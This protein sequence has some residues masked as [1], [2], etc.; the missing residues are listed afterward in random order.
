[1]IQ[2]LSHGQPGLAPHP[3]QGKTLGGSVLRAIVLPMGHDLDI[4]MTFLSKIKDFGL[5]SVYI[6]MTCDFS[7]SNDG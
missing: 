5:F 2:W 1:M 6:C 4:V 7:H 3:C